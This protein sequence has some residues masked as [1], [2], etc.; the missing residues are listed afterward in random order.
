MLNFDKYVDLYTKV[1]KSGKLRKACKKLNPILFH[2]AL[3]NDYFNNF[4]Y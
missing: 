2:S 3:D 4:E 1:K